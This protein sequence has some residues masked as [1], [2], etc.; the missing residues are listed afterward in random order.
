MVYLRVA[1]VCV[2]NVQKV[3][4]G[5]LSRCGRTIPDLRLIGTWGPLT[6]GGFPEEGT[7]GLQLEKNSTIFLKGLFP[8]C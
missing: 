5:G 2:I 6:A 1:S 3:G 7:K 8:Q 4:G